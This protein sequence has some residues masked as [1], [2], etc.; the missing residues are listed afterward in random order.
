VP[1][2]SEHTDLIIYID[3]QVTQILSAN[4]DDVDI[5]IAVS[6]RMN[7]LKALMDSTPKE[8]MDLYCEQYN[9]F[10]L[11]MTL[12]EDMAEAIS[13]GKSL[14]SLPIIKVLTSKKKLCLKSFFNDPGC[15]TLRSFRNSS[16]GLL[17]PF[18]SHPRE[19]KG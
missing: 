6:D 5:L 18:G 19:A 2:N 7:D 11:F 1:L 16:R 9:G 15:V 14:C 3:Q 8:E 10:Y 12:L 13:T 17:V 4:G